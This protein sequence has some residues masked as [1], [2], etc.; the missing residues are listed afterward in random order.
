MPLIRNVVIRDWFNYGASL[1]YELRIDDFSLAMQ[2]Q[3]AA[4]QDVYDFFYDDMLRPATMSGLLSD[5]L[6]LPR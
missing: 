6:T 2:V 5:M 4:T 3:A 1:P